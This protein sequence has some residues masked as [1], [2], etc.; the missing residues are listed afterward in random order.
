M[1]LST[2]EAIALEDRKTKEEAI[3]AKVVKKLIE[4]SPDLL[5][6]ALRESGAV[7]EIEQLKA[8]QVKAGG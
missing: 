2:K 3:L 4:L 7:Q 8:I 5:E 6:H 1:V